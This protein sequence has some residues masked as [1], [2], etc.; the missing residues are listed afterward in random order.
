MT[1]ASVAVS[2]ALPRR[3]R[4]TRGDPQ[5]TG[6]RRV[7]TIVRRAAS[8]GILAVLLTATPG[9]AAP[10]KRLDVKLAGRSFGLA[11]APARLALALESRA[12][13][14]KLDARLYRGSKLV[15]SGRLARLRGRA[16]LVVRVA[17]PVAGRHTLRLRGIDAAGRRRSVTYAVRLVRNRE[18]TPA[19]QP[20]PATGAPAAARSP[21][22]GG[23]G[24]PRPEWWKGW[25]LDDPRLSQPVYDKTI[26]EEVPIVA[27]D[28]TKL[29]AWVIRP[30]TPPGVRVPTIMQLSPYLG[31]PIRREQILQNSQ[32]QQHKFVERGYALIGVSIRGTGASG[33]CLDYEGKRE[34]A[35]YDAIL[36]TIAAQPWSNGKVGAIG[37]SWDGTTL[38]AAALS[39]NRHLKTIV[40]AASITDWY[41]WSFMKGIPAWIVG[42]TF[43]IYGPAVVGGAGV[44]GAGAPPPEHIAQRAC[45]ELADSLAAQETTAAVGTRNAWWD[46]R[47]L[48]PLAKRIDP[49]L[50]VLQVTGYID[51]GVR[52]DHLHEWDGALRKRL[53]NYR[54]LVGDWL[55]LW[56]DTPNVPLANNPD[57]QVNEHPMKSWPTLM[58][59]WFDRWLRDKPTGVEALPP[60]LL[61]GD[62]GRWHEE[63]ALT[64][65]RARTERLHPTPENT[66]APAPA[67]G[68][69]SF[70]DDGANVDPRGTCVWFAG[71]VFIGCAPVDQP[72]AQF[73]VTEPFAKDVR[74]SGIPRARLELAH[75]S[76][77]GQ[78][79]VT[80]Y[81]VD[82][83]KWRPLTYGFASMLLRG[84]DHEAEL[85]E[86]GVPFRQTVELLARDFTIGRGDRLAVAIGSQVGRYPLGLSGNGYLPPPSG[87]VT[88]IRLGASTAVD[89]PRL[90]GVGEPV[91]VP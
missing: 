22:P 45:P 84:S 9:D 80:L 67:P 42:Y 23:S 41:R 33:G 61:Q 35:D 15:G 36:D 7:G 68:S 87:A 25:S 39:G 28:G 88:E 18:P 8:L 4:A 21:A 75:S 62:D 85:V 78:V 27:P 19:S 79:G 74:Y 56:P 58:L 82:G 3:R 64:P 66:L 29:A 51:D 43:N 17:R 48:V 77:R 31:S 76:V 40:P 72:T 16:T 10:A 65:T 59:R 86:P 90:P 11:G 14:R 26:F 32:L 55:H 60:A 49:D 47:D 2:Y 34:R 44:F 50:A 30:Q 71:G 20:A 83:E 37:L 46:E 24:S 5:V 91:A 12:R 53:R 52:P 38:N 70:V 6:A 81:H 54:L 13:V 89:L 69:A 63:D 73:F 1:A 57:V